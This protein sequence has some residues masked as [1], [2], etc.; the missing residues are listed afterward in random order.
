VPQRSSVH[1]IREARIRQATSAHSRTR[2]RSGLLSVV[3]KTLFGV[4][5][6]SKQPAVLDA[7][8]DC[9]RRP[10]ALWRIADESTDE[11]ALAEEWRKHKQSI[12]IGVKL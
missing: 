2:L 3:I 11:S 9:R 1:L 7:N 5:P 4:S 10:G 8:R 6:E 12:L